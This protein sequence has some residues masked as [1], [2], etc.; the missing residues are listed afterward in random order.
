MVYVSA[1][2]ILYGLSGYLA[3][4]GIKLEIL[5]E[6]WKMM[7]LAVGLAIV[8][9]L[10][11]PTVRGVKE[12]D[13]LIAFMRREQNVAGVRQLM[14]D[15][16]FVTALQAGRK[17]SKIKVQLWNGMR[18]EALITSYGGTFSPPTVKLTETET[19]LS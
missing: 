17:G 8:T 18:G 15:A 19:Q 2:L 5:A 3:T 4:I 12:G 1:A 13:Q 11:Y 7:A 16:V 10:A 9:G 6:A 14:T